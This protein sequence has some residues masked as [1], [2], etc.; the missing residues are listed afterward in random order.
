[1]SAIRCV[2]AAAERRLSLVARPGVGGAIASRR[3]S[4]IIIRGDN[5]CM[6]SRH[7]PG[8]TPALDRALKSCRHPPQ[9]CAVHAISR[10]ARAILATYDRALAS[11]GLTST[12]L[13]VLLTLA[14]TGPSNMKTLARHLGADASTMP[15]VLIRLRRKRLV[16]SSAGEDRRHRIVQLTETGA[17]CLEL[18]LP[19]WDA[20]QEQFV[21]RYGEAAWRRSRRDLERMFQA[22]R[23][24]D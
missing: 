3:C 6:R 19:L 22:A 13:N 11:T 9:T 24:R 12:Q 18:A 1:M 5:R 21:R 4:A 15:R 7:G 20:A 16:R 17:R 10:T 14:D 2:I 23:A 8:L